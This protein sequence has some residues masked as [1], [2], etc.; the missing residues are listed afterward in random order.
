MLAK[1]VSTF[2][3]I[4]SHSGEIRFR[5]FPVDGSMELTNVPK[6]GG[7]K[8]DLQLFW[9][10]FPSSSSS[11]TVL[12]VHSSVCVKLFIHQLLVWNVLNPTSPLQDFILTFLRTTMSNRLLTSRC[13]RWFS[14]CIRNGFLQ[15]HMHLGDL[16]VCL[17][18]HLLLV[19]GSSYVTT[20]PL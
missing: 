20:I 4:D 3:R 5:Y 15:P 2:S 18:I 6:G 11:H 10:H 16:L 13:R 19:D 8:I 1:E 9:G 12:L 14:V 17:E 7:G